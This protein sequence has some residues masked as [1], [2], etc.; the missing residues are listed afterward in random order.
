[1]KKQTILLVG[2]ICL[3]ATGT[4]GFA[5]PICGHVDIDWIS[6]HISLPNDAR[7]VLKQEKGQIC[8]VILSIS[9]N[10]AP[11]YAGNDFILV[12]RLYKEGR[13]ITRETMNA[14]SDVIENEREKVVQEDAL[15][16]E[17]RKLFFKQ[18]IQQL[19]E[20]AFLSFSPEQARNFFFVITDPNCPHCS[21]LLPKLEQAA[22]ESK[23]EVKVIIYPILGLKSRNMAIQ[24]ICNNYSYEAYKD[25]KIAES[26]HSCDQAE[27]LL[28]KTDHFF[29]SGGLSAVPIVV[30][31]DGSWVVEN[32]D[33]H[34]IRTYLGIE[35][36]GI[37]NTPI[38]VCP[39]DQ[40]G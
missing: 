29:Q 19:K 30:S 39:S 7:I 22:L 8:E 6:S 28:K 4:N 16:K 23:M 32:N 10:L 17:K 33:I 24:A 37:D 21:D 27:S 11:I 5:D 36:H 1:M 13:Q 38:G 20:I 12:G 3:W 34:Q 9:G 31:G 18:N 35:S 25:I 15:R 26:I 2:L 14:L 40:G